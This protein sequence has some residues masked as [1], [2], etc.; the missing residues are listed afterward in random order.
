MF[1]NRLNLRTRIFIIVAALMVITLTG[2]SVMLWYAYRTNFVF[3]SMID[4]DVAALHAAEELEKALAMQKGFATYYFLNGNPEWLERLNQ[5]RRSFDEWLKKARESTRTDEAKEILDQIEMEY[6]RYVDSKDRVI[7]L[8]K[9]GKREEGAKL[10]WDVRGQFSIIYDLSEQYKKFYEKDIA[11]ARAE[12]RSWARRMSAWTLVSMSAGLL[13]SILLI[14][15]LVTQILEPIRK[16]TLKTVPSGEPAR[17]GNEVRALRESVHGLIEDADHTRTE[18]ERSREL[19]LHSEKMAVVGKLAAEVAHSIRNPMTSIK[20]RLFS[21]KRNLQLSPPQKE[22][23][24]VVSEEMRRLDNI[25]SNFLE[26]SRPPKLKKQKVN[27]SDI[28]DMSLQLLQ[29]RLE[30]QGIEVERYRRRSLPDVNVDP[31]LMKE[32]LVNLIN[33]ACDAM[34][35]GGRLAITEEDAV[36]E[37][38]GRAVVVRVSDNGPG[39]P[40][41]IRNEV[42]K[43]FFSTKET[44]TGLGLSIAVRIVNEHGGRL[45][46][47]SD[48]GT[49][50]TLVIT[51]PAR[52]EES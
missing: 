39:L 3:A 40:E 12:S 24:E 29:N 18:L 42:M 26:F 2:G 6:A 34:G 25:L 44:G 35:N 43:P 38:M 21:M 47:H 36:A 1:W 11:R 5:H 41:S 52:E 9:A 17:Q 33:N 46:L 45:E 20:M 19:L 16:L 31:E 4:T 23:F 15:V 37:R 49:G 28:V 27:V 13:L 30:R 50:T 48:E 7:G 14:F 10:H 32:V 22:D 8:Y 51:L